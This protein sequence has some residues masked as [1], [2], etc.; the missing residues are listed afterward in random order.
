M[1]DLKTIGVRTKFETITSQI[2]DGIV[3]A[4]ADLLVNTVGNVTYIGHEIYKLLMQHDTI[5]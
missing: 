2:E 5:N 1:K 3:T 4:L